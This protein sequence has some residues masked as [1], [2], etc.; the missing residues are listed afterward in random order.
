MSFR[1]YQRS[2]VHSVLWLL[3]S[4]ELAGRQS[5][6]LADVSLTLHGG[7]TAVLG[8]SGA[9]KT[10]LLN[11]LVGFERPTAGV[12]TYSGPTKSG[13]PPV[14]WAP[15]QHGLWSHLTVKQH[16]LTV[17][18]QDQT[19]PEAES[20]RLLTQFDLLNLADARPGSL[21]LGERSRLN[22]VR[23]LASKSPVL[24]MDEPLSH[25]DPGRCGRYWDAILQA[26][27]S[28]RQSLI[29]STHSPDVVIQRADSV[30]CIANGRTAYAGS[31]GELY[32]QP[33]SPELAV[34]LGQCNWM[35]PSELS[36]WC[37]VTD[38]LT[39]P[40]YSNVSCAEAGGSGSELGGECLTGTGTF[41]ASPLTPQGTGS[42]GACPRI[43]AK[44]SIEHGICLRPERIDICRVDDSPLQVQES[45]FAGASEEV[46]ISDDRTGAMRTFICRPQGTRRYQRGER[47][48]V[49]IVMLLIAMF[50]AGCTD[51]DGPVLVVKRETDWLMPPDGPRVPA[52]R[53]MTVSRD[54]EYLVLD[55]A[56]RVLVYDQNGNV[57][58][59]WWMPEYSIGKAEG[60]CVLKD[61]RIA[62]AD[63]HY[64]RIVLFNHDGE[65]AGMFGKHGSG[66]GDFVYPVK[67]M[68]DPDEN[69][70]VCEYGQ[71]DRVQK[72]RS[73]GTFVLQFGGPGTEPGQFQRPCGIVWH[74][75]RVYVVDAFN[76]R[77][78]VFT[79]EGQFVSIL[80]QGENDAVMYYPYDIAIDRHGDLFVVEYGGERVSK[81]NLQ[82]KLLGRYGKAGRGQS[83]G[84][85][86]T[87]WGIA[88]DQRGRVYVC[89]TGNRRI[90]E[91]EL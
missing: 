28:E 34:M 66:P 85:F 6:R 53:G 36:Q 56:G 15:P 35:A 60:I 31:V 8:E 57:E 49:K 1:L 88:A 90:V 9:G 32:E 18:P 73:D 40:A 69:L 33:A 59:Q 65:V 38:G 70:Y 30:V 2:K 82:G 27:D 84:E 47:V 45:R 11:L 4:V 62:V 64:H 12:I 71:N 46:D 25:V 42:E 41:G 44:E 80:Q 89:D 26:C 74:D 10:S 3:Q 86:S 50:I 24:V 20:V 77:I 7:V 23:A 21:S 17:F 43:H 58:R 76:N 37:L 54:S 83:K 22:V 13:R 61:G 52:P 75:H 87:P 78:Q 29:F 5:P 68:Q 72:F 55:N 81:F 19:A 14:F 91:L 39:L 79:D 48:I 16:L 63:T 51:E 67:V